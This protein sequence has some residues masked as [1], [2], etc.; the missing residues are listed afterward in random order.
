MFAPP[1]RGHEDSFAMVKDD[2]KRGFFCLD[3]DSFYDI[4]LYGNENNAN[5]QRLEISLVPCNYLHTRF[6][7]D[8]DSI[9]SECIADKQA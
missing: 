5:Y 4:E 3:S 7:Y 1:S 9:D 8:G 6:G 2:P